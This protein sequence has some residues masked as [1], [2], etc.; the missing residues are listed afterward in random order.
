MS[1]SEGED[2]PKIWTAGHSTR[3]LE[4]FLDLLRANDIGRLVDVRSYPGSKRNPQFNR[5]ALLKSLQGIEVEYHHL[6]E[7]GGRRRP[8][9][10]S[11][12]TAWENPSFR[13]YADYME[14]EDFK[15]G[16]NILLELARERRTAIM[17]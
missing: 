10:N 14:T 7:L 13:A 9:S 4:D 11:M 16:I 2:L 1:V 12:N 3:S 5:S 15:K 8:Q 6:P 17:C